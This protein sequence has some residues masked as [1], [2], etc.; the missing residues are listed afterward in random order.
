[1]QH[2]KYFAVVLLL[3]LSNLF[4]LPAYASICRNYNGHQVCIL[5]IDRSAKNYW[6]YRTIISIDGVKRPSEVYNCRRKIRTQPDG[7]VLPLEEKDPG[8]LIC[9]FFTQ[10]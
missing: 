7:T 4:P 10:H 1:M 5:S 8:R 3:I 6:E 9:E 2:L